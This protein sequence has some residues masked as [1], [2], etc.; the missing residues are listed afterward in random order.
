MR[1]F[2]SNL[3]TDCAAYPDSVWVALLSNVDSEQTTTLHDGKGKA[4]E[5]TLPPHA[6]QWLPTNEL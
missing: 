5:P 2:C 6:A 1:W 4:R 3:N